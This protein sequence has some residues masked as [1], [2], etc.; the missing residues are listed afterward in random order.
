[1]NKKY[2]VRLTES[3]RAHLLELTGRGTCPARKQRRACILLKLDEGP[4]GPAWTDERAA[5]AFDVSK[6][7]AARLR[8]RFDKEGLKATVNR[9]K[10]DRD[11]KQKVDGELEAQ[12][13]RLACSEPPPGHARWSLRLLADRLVELEY[14]DSLSHEAVR[15]VLK[16]TNSSRIAMSS[17]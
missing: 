12:T 7:T 10:P 8:R 17:G 16:K 15:G 11:Y 6:T 2:H 13:V 5:D 4:E 14:V 1:M 3:E 9:K